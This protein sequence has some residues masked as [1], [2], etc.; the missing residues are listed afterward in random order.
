VD[1]ELAAGRFDL[2]NLVGLGVERLAPPV[3]DP[4]HH[5]RSRVPEI[6]KYKYKIVF[7]ALF[8]IS[9][10]HYFSTNKFIYT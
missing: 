5:G 8:T 1:D 4:L 10:S 7:V 2:P 6:E 9:K 3:R